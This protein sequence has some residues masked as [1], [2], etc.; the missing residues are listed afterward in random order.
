MMDADR[1]KINALRYELKHTRSLLLQIIALG[2]WDLLEG[3]PARPIHKVQ[4]SAMG[5]AVTARCAIERLEI[6]EKVA[7]PHIARLF[8]RPQ[9]ICLAATAGYAGD[10]RGFA[11]RRVDGDR[12]R[13]GRRRR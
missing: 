1:K 4:E 13:L 11:N 2:A 3:A 9:A 6:A 10:D 8:H 5:I 12:M 7:C